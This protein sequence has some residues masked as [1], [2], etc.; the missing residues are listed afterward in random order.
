MVGSLGHAWYVHTCA[1][2]DHHWF[3]QWSWRCELSVLHGKLLRLP[4]CWSGEGYFFWMINRLRPTDATWNIYIYIY[5][6]W[7]NHITGRYFMQGDMLV[8]SRVVSRHHELDS[9][10]RSHLGLSTIAICYREAA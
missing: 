9:W 10:C 8:A 6:Y 7:L 4:M 1:R 5:I 3:T 2:I